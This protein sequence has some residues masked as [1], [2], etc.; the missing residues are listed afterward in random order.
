[1][2]YNP[3]IAA[4]RRAAKQ[5]SRER[6][7]P[8]QT[9]LDILARRAG[10]A[11]WDAFLA[12][13]CPIPPER[14]ETRGDPRST[15]AQDAS[16]PNEAVIH[17]GAGPRRHRDLLIVAAILCVAI[18]ATFLLQRT[19]RLTEASAEA[20]RSMV[21]MESDRVE[22][23]TLRFAIN[24]HDIDRDMPVTSLRRTP[25]GLEMSVMVIDDRI[26]S[27]EERRR[28][29]HPLKSYSGGRAAALSMVEHPV[30][31]FAGMV[32]CRAGVFI[33]QRLETADWYRGKTRFSYP[34]NPRTRTW[35]MSAT[36][37]ARICSTPGQGDITTAIRRT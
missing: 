4:A 17:Q 33:P 37:A 14:D 12:D 5:H 11:D 28:D 27:L 18:A 34:I 20:T 36:D 30:S 35:R 9:M 31:R 26:A 8:H 15:T 13:P 25:Q 29:P 22:S 1:M 10:R 19:H 32:D 21:A 2:S 24:D 16:G 7:I 3:D 6:G 23:T